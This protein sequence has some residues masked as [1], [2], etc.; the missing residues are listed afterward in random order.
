MNDDELTESDP[1]DEFLQVED[2]R[3][4][5]MQQAIRTGRR[6]NVMLW[7]II[8]ALAYANIYQLTQ[9]KIV[10]FVNSVDEHGQVVA[11]KLLLARDIPPDDEHR[12]AFISD[13]IK[14]WVVGSRLRS[15]DKK[16]TA[17]GINAALAGSAGPALANLQTE[18]HVEDVW[19]RITVKRE[20]VEV[21][22]PKWPVYLGGESWQAEWEEVVTGATGIEISRQNYAGRFRV[23]QQDQW[24]TIGNP[25]GIHVVEASR[26]PFNK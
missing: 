13:F 16:V 22:M 21:L 12:Q 10:P 18:L 24:V 7:V 5:L 11:R 3:E 6:T 8:L 23:A 2:D 25:Y 9:T 17:G 15:V 26:Q 14:K 4:A 20:S 19:K 1:Y